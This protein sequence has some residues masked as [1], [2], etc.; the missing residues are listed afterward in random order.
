MRPSPFSLK[1]ERRIRRCHERVEEAK[2]LH[3]ESCRAH[4]WRLRSYELLLLWRR[5]IDTLVTHLDAIAASWFLLAALRSRKHIACS[6]NASLNAYLDFTRLAHQTTP[7]RLAMSLDA[8]LPHHKAVIAP[9]L[10]G[11]VPCVLRRYTAVHLV[12]ISGTA[13]DVRN[14]YLYAKSDLYVVEW[15]ELECSTSY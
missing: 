3:A 1:W 11:V 5:A 13:P 6:D 12:G 15:F 2:V 14:G 10:R 8:T 4:L 9:A 7:T